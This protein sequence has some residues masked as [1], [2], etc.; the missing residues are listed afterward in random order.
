MIA[1]RK[2]AG[3]GVAIAAAV[4]NC[5]A[6]AAPGT[7]AA[8]DAR[9]GH[10]AA[11]I[12]PGTAPRLRAQDLGL[13]INTAD[14]YSVA[15]GQ[16]YIRKRA[17]R[18]QQVL[19]VELPLRG[20]LTAEEFAVLRKR[21][22]ARFGPGTQALAL[23][24][25]RPYAVACNS[26]TGALALGF[27]A[28]LCAS[29]CASSRAS[30]YARSNSSRP[31]TAHGM[32]ISMLLAGAD[33][34][35]GKALIDRG[36]AADFTLGLRGAPSA[37]AVLLD[38]ADERRNVRARLYPPAQDIAAAGT[39]VK[40]SNA[41]GLAAQQRVVLAQA[42]SPRLDFLAQ[43]DWLPGGLGDHFTSFGGRLDDSDGQSTVLDWLSAGATAS[44]GTVSEPCNHVQ[45]FPHPQ[46]L[47]AVYLQ[48]GTAIEAYW[49]SVLWPQQSLFV[50]E[51]LAAPYGR[52]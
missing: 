22:D 37:Q 29:P 16:H 20:E 7:G 5:G 10:Q 36:V 43:L 3:W 17:L 9:Q 14:P 4:G 33:V 1:W 25:T 42:G 18:P 28:K 48:G 39:V 35:Q 31:F 12:V 8:P 13:V 46:R 50:G 38:S 41:E 32:R 24:W 21:I 27:D 15:V 44:H 47:L 19:R 52:R 23:A 45:K 26:I 51:P 2:C 34:A 40:R 6:A 49:K 11:R 30:P